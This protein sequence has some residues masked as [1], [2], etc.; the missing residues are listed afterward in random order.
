MKGGL[1]ALYRTLELPGANP[2]KDA[3]AALDAAVL[4]AYGF[5]AKKDLLAQLLELNLAVAQRLEQAEP[6]MAKMCCKRGGVLATLGAALLS[7]LMRKKK[8]VA[9]PASVL[10]RLRI[11]CG[12]DAALG[13]GRV[14]LLEQIGETGSLRAAAEQM[15]MAYMTAWMH[16]QTL[17]RRFRSP[18]VLATRGGKTGG[19]AVLT[20]MGRRVVA[21]YHRMEEQSHAAIQEDFREFQSLLKR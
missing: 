3:H 1:R 9:L 17:N 18:V 16:V 20:D 15:G 19:G 4:A 13:P 6:V 7:I 12:R 5:S 2:L 14:Q 8:C 11:M 10:P 21:L